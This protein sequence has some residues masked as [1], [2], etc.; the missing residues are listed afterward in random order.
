MGLGLIIAL[1]TA[2]HSQQKL[3][4]KNY[5]NS[6]FQRL[7][8]IEGKCLSAFAQNLIGNATKLYQCTELV[9]MFVCA[10]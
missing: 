6:V 2:F 3:F 5:T 10:N 8:K 7:V 4:E 1:W 9:K